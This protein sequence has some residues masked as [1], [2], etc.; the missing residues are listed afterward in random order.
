MVLQRG[1]GSWWEHVGP[2]IGYLLCPD[3]SS[4]RGGQAKPLTF[5]GPYW[6]QTLGPKN[7]GVVGSGEI[8]LGFC[9]PGSLG[10]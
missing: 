1:S 10:E 4:P 2:W 8:C 9:F 5:S 7:V 3:C 6:V